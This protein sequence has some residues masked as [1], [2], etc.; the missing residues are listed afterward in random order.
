MPILQI[1]ALP[2][3]DES[4]ITPALK[5]TCKAIAEC[6]QCEPKH[7]WATWEE[8]KSEFYVEGEKSA[9]IQP[10]DTHPPMASLT[11][12]E[13]KSPEQIEKLLKITSNTLSKELGLGDNIFITYHEAKSGQVISGNQIVRKS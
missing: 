6:Y 9:A 11:C 1:K 12:F 3:K 7:V 13:G 4:K 5:K 2:Q 10:D 8:L